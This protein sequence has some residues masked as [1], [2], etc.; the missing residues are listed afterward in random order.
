MLDVKRLW[1][2]WRG[3][4]TPH[5]LLGRKRPHFLRCTFSLQTTPSRDLF[6]VLCIPS[7]R[8]LFV[9]IWENPLKIAENWADNEMKPSE[10]EGW[11][12]RK[13]GL[14]LADFLA[15]FIE[16][17]RPYRVPKILLIGLRNRAVLCP[18]ALK[19][20]LKDWG[21]LL[22]ITWIPISS[23]NITLKPHQCVSTWAL[24]ERMSRVITGA[25]K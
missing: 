7:Q 15:E 22:V 23:Y 24:N 9:R 21:C 1:G 10:M 25:G 3:D 4:G 19:F 11:R 2:W 16:R 14:F 5:G 8:C 18:P 6:C 12:I 17:A 20:S 13:D